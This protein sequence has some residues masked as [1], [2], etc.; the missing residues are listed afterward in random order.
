MTNEEKNKILEYISE[1][2]DYSDA[3]DDYLLGCNATYRDIYKYVSDMSITES[4]KRTVPIK[5]IFRLEFEVVWK[6]PSC[7]SE[8]LE[9]AKYKYC[10][11]C[12]QMIDWEAEE[13]E[14]YE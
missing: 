5:P 1:K 3:D 14:E 7:K 4:I 12:G 10:P 6:C 8:W 2:V 11:N 9:K 13:E